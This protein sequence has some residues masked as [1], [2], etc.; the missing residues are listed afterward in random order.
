MDPTTVRDISPEVLDENGRMRVLP[1]AYWATTTMHER[2]LFGHRHAV[3]S[4][5]TVELVDRLHELIAGRPAIE[6][7]AGHGVLAEALGFPATDSRMQEKEPA[8]SWYQDRGLPIVR[9]GPDVVE[10][11]AS[12]AVRR[13]RPEVVIGC[14]V[15][16]KSPNG[17]PVGLDEE[18]ILRHCQLYIVVGN[19]FVHRDKPIWKRPHTIE[20]PSY[21]YSRAGNGSREFIACWPGTT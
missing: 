2:V 10:A 21:L 20:Y 13:F 9:Y 19:E 3:Y 1:A 7:G 8:R 11:D 17:N 5:P 14:W 18:D 6:V 12:R 16:H 15:S 4:F